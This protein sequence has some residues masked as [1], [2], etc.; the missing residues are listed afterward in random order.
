MN[1]TLVSRNAQL[2]QLALMLVV[3]KHYVEMKKCPAP[4]HRPAGRIGDR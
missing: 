3:F 2:D 1:D 4:G